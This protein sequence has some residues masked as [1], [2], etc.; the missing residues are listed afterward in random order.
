M[1]YTAVVRI[2]PREGVLDPAGL[3]VCESLR[4][5]GFAAAEVRLGKALRLT[6]DAED[7]ARA[8]AAVAEA[9]RRL[10]ANPVL[11]A[12]EIDELVSLARSG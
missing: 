12:W 9:C 7:E 6:L 11:E 8:R 4:R 1:K 10:L 5:L 3:A 2:W